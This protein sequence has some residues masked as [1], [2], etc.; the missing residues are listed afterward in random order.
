MNHTEVGQAHVQTYQLTVLKCVVRRSKEMMCKY[1]NVR[2]STT[3]CVARNK[4]RAFTVA[5][6][7]LIYHL[8]V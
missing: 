7:S 1:K 3:L 5:L 4:D 8:D 2:L 6:F